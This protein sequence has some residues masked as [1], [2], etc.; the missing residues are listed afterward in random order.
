[1]I[2]QNFIFVG[3]VI[4]LIG[5]YSYILATL[6]GE[7][8][9]NRVTFF[10]WPLA[11]LI[12]FAGQLTKGVGA[13][14]LFSLFVGITPLFV[15]IATFF[16]KKSVWKLTAFDLSCGALSLIGLTLWLITK[17]GNFAIFFGILSD[18]LASLPTVVKSYSHPETEIAWPW[19]TALL[20]SV[21]TLLTI[22][23]WEFA[24]SGF[25]LYYAVDVLIIWF[26]VISKLGKNHVKS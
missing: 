5:V 13:Q 7:I 17:E 15:L 4:N 24:T 25:A 6:K 14:S 8:K 16:N 18:A 11:P 2:N 20:F 9:P 3:F 10:I 22:K 23:K 19:F 21:L 12:I 1:M 26:L